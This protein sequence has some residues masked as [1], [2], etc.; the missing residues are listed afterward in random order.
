M[1]F[2]AQHLSKAMKPK[3]PTSMFNEMLKKNIYVEEKF[4]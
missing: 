3:T 1:K 4:N 2:W